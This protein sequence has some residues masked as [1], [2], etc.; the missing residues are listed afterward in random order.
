MIPA[1]CCL[2]VQKIRLIKRIPLRGPDSGIAD[3]A[4]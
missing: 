4:A 3:D 1:P 2:L